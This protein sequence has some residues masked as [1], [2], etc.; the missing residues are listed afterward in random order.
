MIVDQRLEKKKGEP[1][2]CWRKSIP[3]RMTA[4]GE[5]LRWEDAREQ[6]GYGKVS[7]SD[8]CGG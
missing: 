3:R 4:N 1:H 2:G 8:S 7:N 5:V 6:C